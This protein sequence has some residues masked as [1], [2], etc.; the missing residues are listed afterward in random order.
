MIEGWIR[1]IE[2]QLLVLGDRYPLCLWLKPY[3]S[4]CGLQGE[5]EERK[6]RWKE[7]E[8]GIL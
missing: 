1:S 8:R 6:W 5:E 4:E 7:G 3:A 2:G